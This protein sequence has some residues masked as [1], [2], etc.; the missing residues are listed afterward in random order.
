M[1]NIGSMQR[2]LYRALVMFTESEAIPELA[3]NYDF[4]IA[5][6]LSRGALTSFRVI[7]AVGV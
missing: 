7:P 3:Q 6:S 4:P 5:P 2:S 1:P